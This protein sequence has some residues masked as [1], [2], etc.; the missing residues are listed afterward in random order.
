MEKFNRKIV[1]EDFCYSCKC[2]G[3]LVMCD[4]CPKVFHKDCIVGYDFGKYHGGNNSAVENEEE[5]SWICPWHHCSYCSKTFL[6]INESNTGVLWDLDIHSYICC[7]C[8]LA[9]CHGCAENN[10]HIIDVNNVKFPTMAVV[11]DL[12]KKGFLPPVDCTLYVCRVCEN[13]DDS[14]QDIYGRNISSRDVIYYDRLYTEKI[15]INPYAFPTIKAATGKYISVFKQAEIELYKS[16][17]VD[18]FAVEHQQQHLKRFPTE[19]EAANYVE[20]MPI[21][22]RETCRGKR[23]S[24][25]GYIWRYANS[26]VSELLSRL[27]NEDP[28][29]LD[30]HGNI[31][32]LSEYTT[33]PP[34]TFKINNYSHKDFVSFREVGRMKYDTLKKQVDLYTLSGVFL[35]RFESGSEASRFFGKEISQSTIS[36]CCYNRLKGTN[37][38][39]FRFSTLEVDPANF[40]TLTY[41]EIIQRQEIQPKQQQQQQQRSRV[42]QIT[43]NVYPVLN[44]SGEEIT[45]ITKKVQ[46]SK[47]VE[48]WN[49]NDFLNRQ[50]EPAQPLCRFQ[51]ATDAAL[52]LGMKASGAGAILN[53]CN[54]K[55]GLYRTKLWRYFK[56]P[57]PAQVADEGESM[58]VDS[59]ED[60]ELDRNAP[61][62]TSTEL[63]SGEYNNSGHVPYVT[64]EYVASHKN[65]IAADRDSDNDGGDVAPAT[66]RKRRT[67]LDHL[68]ES[69]IHSSQDDEII[70][71]DTP[72]CIELVQYD[73]ET[74]NVA[75]VL[76]Q[77]SNANN[78]AV[79]LQLNIQE[80]ID[81]IVGATLTYRQTCY[82]WR[83]N[84]QSTSDVVLP[85]IASIQS[86]LQAATPSSLKF[87]VQCVNSVN[88]RV[89][90]N[91]VNEENVNI[92]YPIKDDELPVLD[93]DTE[94][95]YG[96]YLWRKV[97]ATSVAA[98]LPVYNQNTLN[99][100]DLRTHVLFPYEFVHNA[101]AIKSVDHLDVLVVCY[102]LIDGNLLRKFHSCHHAALFI[103]THDPKIGSVDILLM[104]IYQACLGYSYNRA[105]NTYVGYGWKF[106]KVT[107]EA[108][109]F[110]W[111]EYISGRDIT[112]QYRLITQE[113]INEETQI[114]KP[115]NPTSFKKYIKDWAKREVYGIRTS[116]L[117]SEV[118]PTGYNGTDD[119]AVSNFSEPI[120]PGSPIL[121][122]RLLNVNGGSIPL[123]PKSNVSDNWGVDSSSS[124][125]SDTNQVITVGYNSSGNI[126]NRVG[127]LDVQT[128][129]I[130]KVYK[131][132]TIAALATGVSEV[133]IIKRAKSV[134]RMPNVLG[135]QF[136]IKK[137]GEYFG[138]QYYDDTNSSKFVK[139]IVGIAAGAQR[140]SYGTRTSEVTGKKRG[141]PFGYRKSDYITNAYRRKSNDEEDD[142]NYEDEDVDD[143]DNEN[144]KETENENKRFPTMAGAKRSSNG[145][146]FEM[147]VDQAQTASNYKPP[148]SRE[149][150]ILE[151]WV[152]DRV[153]KYLG[154][155]CRRFFWGDEQN[156]IIS[157]GEVI[158]YLEPHLNDGIELYRFKHEDGDEEDFEY[159][160]LMKYMSYHALNIQDDPDD[161]DDVTNDKRYD[162]GNKRRRRM[163]DIAKRVEAF[164]P[165]T[166]CA[167][168]RFE[169]CE[170][171]S[172]LL[173]H[174]ITPNQ[175]ITCCKESTNNYFFDSHAKGVKW[176][177]SPAGTNGV[178]VPTTLD[179]LSLLIQKG[180]FSFNFFTLYNSL[181]YI[182]H[183]LHRSQVQAICS[184]VQRLE[185]VSDGRTNF[186][187]R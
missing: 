61:I 163:K 56:E 170:V 5:Q 3:E 83:Q 50:V 18:C 59:E 181:N 159:F 22:V 177:F 35:K 26:K 13:N 2:G 186:S 7:N 47:V 45:R 173:K 68:I 19:V 65:E 123:N 116:V 121:S 103:N 11:K 175:I 124:D 107:P 106:E 43:V 62:P 169:N 32:N 71:Y 1:H 76:G 79:E 99:R 154:A 96:G 178:L 20:G 94:V 114:A 51:S 101:P 118:K 115:Y 66:R 60:A 157:N 44:E 168:Y 117:T 17:P 165:E 187:G 54:R 146:G 93:E 174:I 151:G 84:T 37:G 4:V 97:S 164:N 109:S 147:D 155:K 53:I 108:F 30:E 185:K 25:R 33:L 86:L 166:D 21:E 28:E 73:I 6:T 160:E 149:Q 176:R 16:Q 48:C 127:V 23:R 113:S 41:E 102:S 180:K 141:R 134:A 135:F 88:Y 136:V 131:T 40:P 100:Y 52:F 8:T 145:G 142:V 95:S 15:E 91:F 69:T 90:K 148:A 158:G 29:V 132:A 162:D 74:N 171:A 152:F 24:A 9:L 110:N 78:A 58:I 126:Q 125:D 129:K 92:F 138:L 38:F 143:D 80:I 81:N 36:A 72:Q 161:R 85:D 128:G 139:S 137:K 112:E 153:D 42:P 172:T 67:V 105:G 27:E 77:F 63:L 12:K 98:K 183:N 55:S 119:A 167:L 89:M 182:F 87:L 130:S 156:L 46:E 111:D 122:H 70:G 120:I 10:K 14:L 39:T 49:E 144:E 104:G 64:S 179:E 140:T 133:D 75:T 34:E 31:K 150:L 57:L 82:G 184:Y